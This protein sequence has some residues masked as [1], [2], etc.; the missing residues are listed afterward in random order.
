MATRGKLDQDKDQ[1]PGKHV[2]TTLFEEAGGF[3]LLMGA[4]VT[5]WQLQISRAQLQTSL[6]RNRKELDPSREARVTELFTNATDRLGSESLVVRLGGIYA[7]ERIT[8]DSPRDRRPIVEVLSALVRERARWSGD[9]SL[10]KRTRLQSPDIDI[11]AILTVLGR[12]E[13][14]N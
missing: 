2:R 9:E 5:W 14:T 6:E 10:S 8:R 7:L 11:Q 4:I 3:V 13:V 1:G 12:R